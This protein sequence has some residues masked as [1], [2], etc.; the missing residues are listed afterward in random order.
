[1]KGLTAEGQR[2]VPRVWSGLSARLAGPDRQ[3]PVSRASG[4]LGG[5]GLFE[6]SGLKGGRGG[7]CLLPGVPK[8]AECEGGGLGVPE[9]LLLPFPPPRGRAGVECRA[10]TREWKPV[11]RGSVG[12]LALGGPRQSTSGRQ[13]ECGAGGC[14]SGPGPWAFRPTVE[15]KERCCGGALR[16]RIGCSALEAQVWSEAQG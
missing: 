2:P 11:P 6:C 16:Q 14:R 12:P 8:V 4:R 3:H 7:P 1:M 5:G 10:W 15:L 13:V 9:I